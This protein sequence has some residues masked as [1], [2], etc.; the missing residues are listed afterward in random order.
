MLSMTGYAS[1]TKELNDGILQIDI[2]SVNGKYSDVRLNAS[3]FDHNF[4]EKLRKCA[5]ERVIRGQVTIDISL[6]H[7]HCS[8]EA[9]R[10]DT[11]QLKQYMKDYQEAFGHI[12]EDY[13]HLKYFLQLDHITKKDEYVFDVEKDG[14]NVIDALNDAFDHFYV[15]REEEGARLQENLQEKLFRL[16]ATRAKIAERVPELDHLY[17]VRLETRIR[18][19]VSEL[20]DIDESRILSEVAVHAVK[21]TIDEELVRLA[22]HFEKLEELLASDEKIVG[23][24]IDFYMQE[25]NREYNTIASKISDIQVSEKIVESKVLIDQIREQAQNIM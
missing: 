1:V 20:D 16:K 10:L 19:F 9:F 22:S 3:V 24:K 2:K 15:S 5:V 12:N 6:K 8:E 13:K 25:I 18:E 4:L 7:N 21:T 23:K 14:E 11:Q 17:R